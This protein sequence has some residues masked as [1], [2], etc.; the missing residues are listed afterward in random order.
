MQSK[1]LKVYPSSS[2]YNPTVCYILSGGT[3]ALGLQL[4]Q[5]MSAHGAK[6]FILLSRQGINSLRSSDVTIIYRLKR[7]RI[8]IYVIFFS[9]AASTFGNPSQGNYSATNTFLDVYAGLL[10]KLSNK[11]YEFSIWV[12]WRMLEF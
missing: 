10:S 12:L 1:P 4:V 2:I 6:Q 8:R 11:K 5:H 9:S 7:F 3:E